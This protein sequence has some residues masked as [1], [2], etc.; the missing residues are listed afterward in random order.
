MNKKLTRDFIFKRTQC[1]SHYNSKNIVEYKIIKNYIKFVELIINS[2]GK[3][4]EIKYSI[5]F[6]TKKTCI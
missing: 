4:N 3:I 1:M 2:D 5:F 6:R